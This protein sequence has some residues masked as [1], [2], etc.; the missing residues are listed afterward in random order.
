MCY[1]RGVLDCF[2]IGQRE[3]WNSA[4]VERIL[5]T[6]F[7]LST[8]DLSTHAPSFRLHYRAKAKELGMYFLH[9]PIF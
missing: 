2:I 7:L 9:S 3:K 4:Q 6:K 5:L 8:S 1:Y